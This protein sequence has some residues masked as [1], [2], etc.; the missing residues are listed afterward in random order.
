MINDAKEE[1]EKQRTGITKLTNALLAQAKTITDQLA[2]YKII[3]DC[4]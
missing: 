1:F 2:A 3:Y 4:A